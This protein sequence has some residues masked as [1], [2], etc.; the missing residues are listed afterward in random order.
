MFQVLKNSL[1][2]RRADG[3]VMTMTPFLAHDLAK[4][5]SL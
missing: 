4:Q 5:D 2:R 1:D 3:H